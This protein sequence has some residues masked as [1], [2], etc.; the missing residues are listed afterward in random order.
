M[1]DS[2]KIKITGDDSDFMGKL[3]GIGQKA[4]GIFKGMMASQIVT[5]GI[6]MLTSGLKSAIDTGMQ[7]EAAMS[8]VAAISGATGAELEQLTETA[9]HYGETT[10]FSASQA[11]EALK[12]MA[13]AGWGT[14]Q[15]IEALPGVLDL[16]ASSG[17]DLGRASDAVADYLSAFGMEASQAGYM[18]DLMAHAQSNANTS[19]SQLSDAYGN[20]AS[21]IS[22]SR[23]SFRNIR[24]VTGSSA[25]TSQGYFC[26]I[27]NDAAGPIIDPG[28]RTDTLTWLPFGNDFCASTRPSSMMPILNA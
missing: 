27:E 14:Q 25:T 1:A 20:C 22:E 7:F 26:E 15:S 12:Y 24:T 10:M 11:A 19:A 21:S 2:V 4:G 3:S 9:K 28:P 23:S 8:Q 18:A 17:M 16:A 5:K 13:L 6:S